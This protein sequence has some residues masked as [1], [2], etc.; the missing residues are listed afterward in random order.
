MHP[1]PPRWDPVFWRTGKSGLTLRSVVVFFLFFH[2]RVTVK[3]WVTG[4]R[5]TETSR[6]HGCPVLSMTKQCSDGW[7]CPCP[8]IVS[9]T[10]VWKDCPFPT[11]GSRGFKEYRPFSSLLHG[12]GSLDLERI[13]DSSYYKPSITLILPSYCL[14]YWL[15]DGL[16]CRVFLLR[17][18]KWVDE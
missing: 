3:V 2:R 6:F 12:W 8:V 10:V 9:P 14:R 5:R 4:V 16:R 15:Q 1:V 13:V 17:T 11:I 18:V 7:I